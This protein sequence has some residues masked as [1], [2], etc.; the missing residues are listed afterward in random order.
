MHIFRWTNYDVEPSLLRGAETDLP[1]LVE[2]LFLAGPYR[3]SLQLG[4]GKTKPNPQSQA[5]AI[6]STATT[7]LLPP[8]GTTTAQ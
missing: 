7:S 1:V 3:L 5:A 2:E 6:T 4:A 8:C